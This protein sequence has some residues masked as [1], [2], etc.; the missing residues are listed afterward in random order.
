MNRIRSIEELATA[1]EHR[2]A[3]T[4][5]DTVWEKPKPASVILHLQGTIIIKL[6]RQGMYL[7]STKIKEKK[8]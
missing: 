6:L 2:R 3:V 8:L 7:Y 1:A 5:P 4:I